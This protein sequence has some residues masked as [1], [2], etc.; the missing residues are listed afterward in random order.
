MVIKFC[1]KGYL[2]SFHLEKSCDLGKRPEWLGDERWDRMCDERQSMGSRQKHGVQAA[3]GKIACLLEQARTLLC[4]YIG[5]GNKKFDLNWQTAVKGDQI[6]N[7][8]WACTPFLWNV[9]PNSSIW[10]SLNIKETEDHWTHIMNIIKN[11]QIICFYNFWTA[12]G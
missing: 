10:V 12:V 1:W 5:Q 6:E 4:E 8:E 11:E 2:L 7:R 9:S 3:V